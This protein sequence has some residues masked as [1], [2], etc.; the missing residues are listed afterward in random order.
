VHVCTCA[1]ETQ[2]QRSRAILRG[3]GPESTH[4]L[5]VVGSSPTRPTL[6]K[7]LQ[8]ND[9]RESSFPTNLQEMGSLVPF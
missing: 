5:V 6:R 2:R 1:P 8:Q 9:F 7:L 4:N 3:L